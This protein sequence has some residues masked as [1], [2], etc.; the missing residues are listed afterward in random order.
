MFVAFK[1]HGLPPGVMGA[2]VG[3]GEHPDILMNFMANAVARRLA[4]SFAL[5]REPALFVFRPGVTRDSSKEPVHWLPSPVGTAAVE[6]K[7]DVAFPAL[8]APDAVHLFLQGRHQF[9]KPVEGDGAV[10]ARDFS[11]KEQ[12]ERK[13]DS[14]DDKSQ[15]G[16]EAPPWVLVFS[17]PYVAYLFNLVKPYHLTHVWLHGILQSGKF[18]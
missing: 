6:G 17:N 2:V 11:G 5:S 18:L 9:V 3:F 1:V 4:A 10:S 16:H 8:P 15:S 12:A 13:D 14:E 7:S